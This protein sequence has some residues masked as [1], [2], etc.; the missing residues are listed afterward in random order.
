MELKPGYKQTE[1]GMI[2]EDWDI[3][4]LGNIIDYTKGFAFK[5]D[6]YQS[7]GVRIIRVSDTT[8]DSI[9]NVNQIYIDRDKAYLYDK[10]AL[11]EHDLVLSTVGS[12]PPMYD[13][14]VG[15]AIIIEKQYDGVLLNQNAVLFRSKKRKSHQQKLLL[16]HFRTKRYLTYI[17]SIFRGNANQASITLDDLFHFQLALP[18]NDAEQRAIATALS[19]VDALITSLDRLIAKKRDIKQATMQQL[20]TGRTRLLG[21]N[22]EWEVKKLGKIAEIDNDNLNSNTHP[23]YSF[24]YISL[25]DVDTGVLKRYSEITFRDAP[26]RAKRKVKKNDILVSTVRPNLKSHLYITDDIPD[27]VCSTGFSVLRCYQAITDPGYVY[28]HLFADEVGRQIE[29]LLTGSNY[30]AINGGDVRALEI[31]FPPLSEQRAIAA[32]LSDMDAEI[33]ALE[34]KRDKTRAL[35]QG[36]M[37]ELLTGKTRLI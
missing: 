1:M 24:K 13:S 9:K 11:K 26:S 36:M 28:F 5:S 37:Q 30:P 21:F 3:V 32:I 2:P 15:K 10:W 12:K 22:G 33:T 7:D 19:D 29:S 31:P 23:D 14:M 6:D 27:L 34:Q 16:N 20:L 8:F 18:G 4:E 17:E 25:E 35:K